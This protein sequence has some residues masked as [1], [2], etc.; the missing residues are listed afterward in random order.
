MQL[1]CDWNFIKRQV[2]NSQ[3]ELEKL[4]ISPALV[5][6]LIAAEDHRFDSHSGVD[7]VS[8]CRAVWRTLFFGKREGGSTIAMQLVRVIS[9]RYERTLSRKI[10]EMYYAVR[11]TKYIGKKNLPRIYLMVA[12]YGWK[13]N[14]LTQA[15]KRMNVDI[16]SASNTEAASIVARL[17]YPEPQRRDEGRLTKI[18]KRTDYILFRSGAQKKA[19]L[20]PQL[21]LREFNGSI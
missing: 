1:R 18:N 10:R 12:Y 21:N 6:M 8:M 7:F 2:K 4:T 17:K 20:E 15:S 14:G 9:G 5:S 3:S 11:L 19:K 16:S 13:M